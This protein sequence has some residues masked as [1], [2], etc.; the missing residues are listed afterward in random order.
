MAVAR[1]KNMED[2]RGYYCPIVNDI[3]SSSLGPFF[4]WYEHE[5][6]I[7]LEDLGMQQ[8]YTSVDGVQKNSD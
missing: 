5:W 6:N 3:F 7:R 1:L 8:E 2:V 4:M